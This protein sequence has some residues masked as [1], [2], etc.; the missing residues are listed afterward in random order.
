MNMMT[1]KYRAFI[2]RIHASAWVTG[3]LALAF[4]LVGGCTKEEPQ[5]V[6]P[7]EPSTEAALPKPE[8]YMKDPVFRQ[9]LVEQRE[10]RKTLLSQRMKLVK[11]L[12]AKS[13]AMQAAMPGATDAEIVAALEKDPE[14]NSLVKRVEDLVTAADENRA[15]T[16][17]TVRARLTTP[18][19]ISK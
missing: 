16:L 10:A 5:A 6:A 14:W 17:E 19:P 11:Q 18:Q 15:E 13:L 2:R 8:E 7:S 1:C 12:E 9:K 4:L 3:A